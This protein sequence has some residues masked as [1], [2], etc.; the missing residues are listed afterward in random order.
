VSPVPAANQRFGFVAVT[1]GDVNGDGYHDLVVGASQYSEG[2]FPQRGAVFVVHGGPGGL[3]AAPARTLIGPAEN[4]SFGAAAVGAGDVDADGYADILVGASSSGVAF[5]LGGAASLFRGSAG[6]ILAAADTTIKGAAANLFCGSSVSPAGDVNGDGYAD[7]LVGSP[8]LQTS[9]G[10]ADLYFGGPGGIAS[11]VTVTNIQPEPNE[12]FGRIVTTLGDLDGDGL[13]DFGVSATDA[14]HGGRGRIAVYRGQPVSYEY[15]GEVLAPA[16]AANF[17]YT[18]SASGDVDGD[19]RSEIV[20]GDPATGPSPGDSRGRAHLFAAPRILPRLDPDWP[21]PGPQ[22]GTGYAS[23]VA[24]LPHRTGFI[25]FPRVAV[26][27]PGFDGAG[28]L[29]MHIGLPRTGLDVDEEESLVGPLGSKFGARVV[30]AGDMDRNGYTDVAVSS[31]SREDG[32]TIQVGTVELIRGGLNGTLGVQLVLTGGHEFDRV[33]SAL[34]GRGDVDGDGYHDLLIGAQEWDGASLADCGKVWLFRGSPGG[35]EPVATWQK[36]GFQLGQGYGAAVALADLDADGYSDVIVGSSSP[37][38]ATPIA[39]KVEVYYGG[40]GG[41]PTTPGLVLRPQSPAPSYG[42]VVAS[43]GDV[44]GDGVCDLGV[45]APL[46]GGGRAF[47]YVGSLGRSQSQRPIWTRA[48]TQAGG[49]FGAAMAGG[50]DVDGDGR[51]DFVVGEPYW[52]GGQVQEGRILLFHGAPFIPE[53]VPWTAESDLLGA[54]LGASFA[55]LNDVTSDGFA[56]IVAGA[57]GAAGR[58]FPFLGGGGAGGMLRTRPIE[59]EVILTDRYHPARLDAATALAATMTIGSPAG[60]TRARAAFEVTTQNAPFTGTP[61]YFELDEYDNQAS[62]KISP[63]PFFHG[64]PGRVFRIRGRTITRSP[65]FPRS[66]WVTPEAHVSGDYDVR[67][68]GVAV[69]VTDPPAAGAEPRLLGVEPSPARGTDA[70]RVRFVLPQSARVILD[71]HD[72]R[73]AR[74]ARIADATFAAGPGTVAWDGR[75]EGGALV[76]AGLYFVTL[77]AAGEVHRGRIV[78]LR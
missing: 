47:V 17:G 70:T 23:S 24:I 22:P 71:V 27:D 58:L 48:G 53:P 46:D 44:T 63:N 55:P 75:D 66:R 45:G 36:E 15:L 10:R 65:Y 68:A 11:G 76:P 5:T 50:G 2:G 64:W 31:P 43:V 8:G 69:G 78:R 52:D 38:S 21:R 59:P 60:R 41:P 33:G 18:V 40:P 74:V 6:G 56:D 16:G 42:S 9:M 14:L 19:G 26:G 49:R 57:P 61:T 13:A 37:E 62:P 54:H 28:R 73:G 7:V 1:A 4:G 30:D 29:S 12:R 3:A 20:V 67:A 77:A 51:G 35:A 34:A 32:A 39:G 25:G 72:V